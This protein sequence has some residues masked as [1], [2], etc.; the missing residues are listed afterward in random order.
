VVLYTADAANS[1]KTSAA[2]LEN[3]TNKLYGIMSDGHIFMQWCCRCTPYLQW[4][5]RCPPPTVF[6][7]QRPNIPWQ[8]QL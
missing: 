2:I 8:M 7:L 5:C 3:H 4:C 6:T 1:A